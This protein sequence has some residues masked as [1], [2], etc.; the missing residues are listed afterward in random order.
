MHF[1]MKY[2]I[3]VIKRESEQIELDAYEMG[4]LKK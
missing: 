2:W 3:N 1:A 4:L